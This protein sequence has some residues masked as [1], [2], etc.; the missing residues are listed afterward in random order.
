MGLD[1]RDEVKMRSVEVRLGVKKKD[2]QCDWMMEVQLW[3]LSRLI[4][5]HES[6]PPPLL[7][8]HFCTN[9]FV[10]HGSSKDQVM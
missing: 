3:L 7:M 9:L 8:S 10:I 4:V 6:T 1:V 5:R 2:V